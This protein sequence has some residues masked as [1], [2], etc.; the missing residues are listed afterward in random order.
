[1]TTVKVIKKYIQAMPIKELLQKCDSL[2]DTIQFELINLSSSVDL[3]DNWSWYLYYKTSMNDGDFDPLEVSVS[4]D[5]SKIYLIWKP[6][7]DVTQTSGYLSIQIRAKKDSEDGL[8]KWNS[9]ISTIKIGDSILVD[10]EHVTSTTLEE[11]LDSFERIAQNTN[12]D[13]SSLTLRV[14]ELEKKMENV[15]QWSGKNH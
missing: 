3:T 2:V 15:L 9:S 6:E 12:I 1:M 10:S 8:M 4:E 13:I 14:E 5:K 7:G 11:Y